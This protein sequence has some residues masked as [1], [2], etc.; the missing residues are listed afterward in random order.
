M[1]L[2]PL[3]GD[4]FDLHVPPVRP[5]DMANERQTQARALDVVHQRI[6]TAVKLLEDFLLLAGRNADSM[7]ADFQ[8]HA[9][10]GAVQAHADELAV[11]RVLQ[12][13]VHQIEQ[14]ARN[15]FAV[16]VHRRNIAGDVFL[17]RKTV[18][19]DLEAV[20]IER[21]RERDRRDWSP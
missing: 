2:L 20:R 12:S 13:V 19:L 11:F 1:N 17:E 8:L 16:H 4:A 21:G 3:S 18:L 10:V 9:T 7:V 5:H 6:A 14:R 15:G